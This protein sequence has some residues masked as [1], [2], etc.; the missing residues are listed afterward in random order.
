MVTLYM[1]CTYNT[2][3]V[4]EAYEPIANVYSPKLKNMV[5]SMLR[6]QPEERPSIDDVI[7]E[8]CGLPFDLDILNAKEAGK[9]WFE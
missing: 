1:L 4:T 5:D 8:I 9:Q 7:D 2:P 6:K 3:P